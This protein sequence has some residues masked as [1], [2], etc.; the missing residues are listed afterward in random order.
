MATRLNKTRLW[1]PLWLS[2]VP[3]QALAWGATGHRLVSSIG[4]NSLPEEIP[5]F[6][7]TSEAVTWA[8]ELGREPDRSKGSGFSHDRDLDPG[9]YLDLGDSG[10]V[11]DVIPLDPLSPSR[12]EYDTALRE[13]GF[14]EYQAGFL[15]YSIIDGW[16]QIRKDFAY[17]RA[18]TAGKRL[19]KTEE[20]R[21]WYEQDRAIRE[22]L[23]VRDLG[24][25]SHFVADASQPLHV[26][27]HYN[28]WGNYPNP[29]GFT[30]N[31]EL[32]ATF[33][34]KY[35][36]DAVHQEDI[37][38]ALPSPRNLGC[39]IEQQTAAYLRETSRQ[40]IPLYRLE[41]QGA[42]AVGQPAGK[43]FVTA[44]LAAGAA[45]LRDLVIAAWRCSD[46][47]AVG[48]PPVSVK[49]VESGTT[50]PYY[51]LFGRD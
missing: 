27:I 6:L 37:I 25:W 46:E 22:M 36:A 1:F 34:G 44:R 13:K 32:H 18:D 43:S 41:K 39:A 11:A 33:E 31:R 4:M 17:W 48:Y 19:A 24:Y 28:G 23:T 9:H 14:D 50:D 45:E 30:N 21:A 16:Q 15:P 29:D 26:S 2:L 40:V 35:V 8:G 7:R 3:F 20:E 12:Q 10:L 38:A 47:V 51:A 42:F 49:D 5:A